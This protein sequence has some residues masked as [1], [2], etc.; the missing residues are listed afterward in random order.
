[1]PTIAA[2]GRERWRTGSYQL[3]A[4]R[5][6]QTLCGGALAWKADARRPEDSKLVLPRGIEPRTPS[7]PRTCSTTELRQRCSGGP[8]QYNEALELGKDRPVLD[9]ART[10]HH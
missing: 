2:R 8:S 4:R 5:L 6:L 9:R 3:C 7:L 10:R 1:M